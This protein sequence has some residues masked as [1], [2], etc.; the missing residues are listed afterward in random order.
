MMTKGLALNFQDTL[1]TQH[2][3][4]DTEPETEILMD[5]PVTKIISKKPKYLSDYILDTP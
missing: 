3:F 1:D 5:T 2:F 4:I